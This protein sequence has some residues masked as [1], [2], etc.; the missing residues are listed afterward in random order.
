MRGDRKINEAQAGTVRE[1]F[2]RF[3]AGEGRGRLRER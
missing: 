1:I 3:A 2:R